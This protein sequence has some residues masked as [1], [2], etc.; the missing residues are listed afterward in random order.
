MK[1]SPHTPDF[2]QLATQRIGGKQDTIVHTPFA[3]LHLN[4]L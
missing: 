2:Q 1:P 4:W 3:G